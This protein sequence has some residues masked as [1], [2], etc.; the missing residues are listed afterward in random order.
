VEKFNEVLMY[1]GSA[2]EDYFEKYTL[3]GKI[4]RKIIHKLYYLHKKF[5]LKEKALSLRT[6]FE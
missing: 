4:R 3:S 1:F 5:F 2:L 6:Y